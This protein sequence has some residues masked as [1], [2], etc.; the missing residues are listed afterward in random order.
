MFWTSYPIGIERMSIFQCLTQLA[1]KIS[2]SLE[3]SLRDWT[4]PLL[5]QY[6][7]LIHSYT[8]ASYAVS[9]MIGTLILYLSCS[10]SNLFALRLTSTWFH[11]TLMIV[12]EPQK[13]ADLASV[14]SRLGALISQTAEAATYRKHGLLIEGF[15]K[16]QLFYIHN[17]IGHYNPSVRIYALVSHTT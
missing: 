6:L 17:I 7:F 16:L 10:V 12:S 13:L 3:Y 14:Y 1:L 5:C 9:K 4:F 2:V 11:L 15:K 8:T